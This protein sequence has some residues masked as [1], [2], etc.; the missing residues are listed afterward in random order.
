M[1][2]QLSETIDG[3]VDAYAVSEEDAHVQTLHRMTDMHNPLSTPVSLPNE[4]HNYEVVEYFDH[5]NSVSILGEVIGR[6]QTRRL[7]QLCQLYRSTEQREL[8]GLDP[9]AVAYL[10]SR[11]V[12]MTPPKSTW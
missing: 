8:S 10:Y 6:R 7:S 12:F 1:T 2:G 5:L 3:S 4:P 11:Q 9:P